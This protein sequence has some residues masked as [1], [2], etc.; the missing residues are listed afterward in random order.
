MGA[1]EFLPTFSTAD[2]AVAQPGKPSSYP[3]R[4]VVDR[5]NGTAF[6]EWTLE[7]NGAEYQRVEGN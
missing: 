4:V 7:W 1:R 3:R 6:E 2:R 5:W